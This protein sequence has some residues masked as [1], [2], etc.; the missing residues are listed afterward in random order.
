MSVLCVC[1][2]VCVRA[3]VRA[4]VFSLCVRLV[5][6]LLLNADAIPADWIPSGMSR[7]VFAF[8]FG[9]AVL[10]ISC[11]CSLGL[12][13]PTAVRCGAADVWCMTCDV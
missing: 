9:L 8:M 13:T 6:F 1:V 7:F 12:A 3:C 5:W 2:C 11:P 10:V 4:C